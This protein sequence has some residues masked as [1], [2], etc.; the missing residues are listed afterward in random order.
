M[1]KKLLFRILL[2]AVALVL[3]Y[4][5]VKA[6]ALPLWAQLGVYLVPYLII[7]YDV[8]GEAVEEGIRERNPFNEDFLMCIATIGALCIGFSR[9]ASCSRTMPRIRA[10]TPLRL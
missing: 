3:A 4:L 7:S 2:T 5:F 1:D 8:M 10:A 9:W 6:T